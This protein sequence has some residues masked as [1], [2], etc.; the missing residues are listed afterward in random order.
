MRK[1]GTSLV[2][3]IGAA[4][5]ISLAIITLVKV[6][7]LSLTQAESVDVQYSVLSVDAFLADIY[8]DFHGC[9]EYD[10]KESPSGQRSLSFTQPD[11]NA[12]IYSFSPQELSCYKNG[13]FQ[14][15]ATR[16]ECVGTDKSLTVSVKLEDHR[17]LQYTIY[18]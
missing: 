18:R 3:T 4:L 15:K 6:S 11:G 16:F 9:V 12:V 2:E 17:L 13:I 8:D 5:I 10:Y 1:T 14:F 7:A